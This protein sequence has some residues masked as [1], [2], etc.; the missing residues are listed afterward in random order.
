[1]TENLRLPGC[2]ESGVDILEL[3]QTYLSDETIGLWLLVLD[4][5]DNIDL[6]TAPL[7]S[8]A[9]AKCLIGYMPRSRHGAIWFDATV[10]L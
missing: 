6:W 8:E 2:E 3:V 7:T 10:L 5:A 4:N 1:V 9:G